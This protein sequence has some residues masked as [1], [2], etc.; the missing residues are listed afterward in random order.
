M[1]VS[2]NIEVH[3]RNHW[4]RGKRYY[5][6]LR[7][8]A[9]A[10]VCVCVCVCARARA[11]VG[12]AYAWMCVCVWGCTAP[13]CICARAGLLIQ[14]ATRKRTLSAASLAPPYFLILC[15]N[16]HD[17]RKKVTQH[18]TRVLIFY[19]HFIWNM[20]HSKK[21]SARYCHKC[22][23]VFMES[24]RC[25]SR[26]LVKLQFSRHILELCSNIKFH[27]N[28]SSGSRVVSCKR[29]DRQT[30]MMKLTVTF[31]DFAKGPKNVQGHVEIFGHD[32]KRNWTADQPAVKECRLMR[33]HRM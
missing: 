27:Q 24:T 19:T 32:I 16:R 15:H 8:R 26:I 23:N 33:A 9:R 20:S 12:A 25:F 1:Y 6:F 17:F 28:P 5:K 13:A 3:W 4:C 18:K 29:M 10:C 30:D 21:N 14:Y 31:R 7:A 11:W 2:R 22:G